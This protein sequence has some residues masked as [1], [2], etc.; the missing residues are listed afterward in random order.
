MVGMPAA[1]CPECAAE[2]D[3]EVLAEACPGCGRA[4][5]SGADVADLRRDRTGD[6][7][8]DTDT[9]DATHA[10]GEDSERLA[11]LYDRLIGGVSATLNVLEIGAGSGNLTLGLVR[12]ARVARLVST[13]I[14]PAFLGRLLARAGP[15]GAGKLRAALVDANR[16]P[17]PDASFDAVVG[18]SVLHHIARFEDT[19]A[20]AARI[21]G[22]GGAAVFGEPVLDVHAIG[23]LAAAVVLGAGENG[24]APLPVEARRVLRFVAAR[25]GTKRANFDGDRDA[26]GK[27]EDKFQFS[28]RDMQDAGRS[29]GFQVIEHHDPIAPREL[30][31]TARFLIERVCDQSRVDKSFLGDFGWVF[32]AI[33][34]SYARPL[35]VERGSPF[36]YFIFH[37][38]R[39]T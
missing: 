10:V 4:M 29:A 35:A 39:E 17:F 20:D 32:D 36:G 33:T 18:H 27:V 5:R 26:L 25:A 34:R 21:V 24:G 3:L 6:T 37:R 19:L 22:P 1:L 7:L 2:I 14:S 13:D 12:R 8:L 31:E 16:L 30:G 9:Y 23:S 11:E 38:R 15:L 28:V